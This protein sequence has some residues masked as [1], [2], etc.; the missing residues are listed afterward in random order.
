MIV[1]LLHEIAGRIQEL[2]CVKL[3]EKYL[4]P[5]KTLH[6]LCNYNAV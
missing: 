1:H 5:Q 6:K 3:L 4:V 2:M